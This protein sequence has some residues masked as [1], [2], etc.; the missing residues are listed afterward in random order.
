MGC[1]SRTFVGVRDRGLSNGD[2]GSGGGAD[3]E[4][5]VGSGIGGAWNRFGVGILSSSGSGSTSL[6]IA[7]IAVRSKP[8]YLGNCDSSDVTE[9][10]AA[11][12]A[13]A[14]FESPTGIGVVGREVGTLAFTGVAS[15]GGRSSSVDCVDAELDFLWCDGY[16]D[17]EGGRDIFELDGG[18]FFFRENQL[19]F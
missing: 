7:F 6:I 16:E 15:R 17:T 2:L 19:R 11:G 13:E 10:V 18:D 14:S 1:C 9:S 8:A 3:S 5:S 12:D 4:R